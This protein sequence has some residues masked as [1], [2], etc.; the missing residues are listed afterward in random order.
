LLKRKRCCMWE[1]RRLT[2]YQLIFSLSIMIRFVASS[3]YSLLWDSSS[4]KLSNVSV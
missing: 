3:L 1:Y 2:H 4:E